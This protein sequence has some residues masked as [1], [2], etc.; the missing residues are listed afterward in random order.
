MAEKYVTKE[1]NSERMQQGKRP[2]IIDG[3]T[4]AHWIVYQYRCANIDA[5]DNADDKKG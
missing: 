5:Q 2:L 1:K 4:T 3:E